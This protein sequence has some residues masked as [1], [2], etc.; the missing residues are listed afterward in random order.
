MNSSVG[1][2]SSVFPVIKEVLESGIR[3][4]S[5]SILWN[6]GSRPYDVTV[7]AFYTDPRR[8]DQAVSVSAGAAAGAS[9]NGATA[10]NQGSSATKPA[11]TPTTGATK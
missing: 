1:A 6:E 7:I 2:M 3:R 11:T 4:L 8:V 5:V 10:T 9:G